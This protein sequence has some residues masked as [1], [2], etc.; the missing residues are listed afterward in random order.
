MGTAVHLAVGMP[1]TTDTALN[2][3]AGTARTDATLSASAKPRTI[4]SGSEQARWSAEPNNAWSLSVDP[5][6]FGPLLRD[7]KTGTIVISR[8]ILKAA[9]SNAAIITMPKSLLEDFT[10]QTAARS[11]DL[12]ANRLRK[13]PKYLVVK[14]T[15]ALKSDH[16]LGSLGLI[17][18]SVTAS[19][20]QNMLCRVPKS[21]VATQDWQSFAF[22]DLLALNNA[23][24]PIKGLAISLFPA[25][26]QQVAGYG[27][28]KSCSSISLKS[29]KLKL[30]P[31]DLPSFTGKQVFYY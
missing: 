1:T 7:A 16:T 9:P 8:A 2:S 21:I 6:M 30:E 10:A 13:R 26:W 15:G 22:T 31:T 28:D 23:N 11:P 4:D 17:V 27:C 24:D 25:P 5:Q 3:A 19:G 20:A 29:L 12:Q 18:S 14:L